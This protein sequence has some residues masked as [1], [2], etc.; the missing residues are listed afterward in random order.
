MDTDSASRI[1][2]VYL[3]SVTEN[4]KGADAHKIV[5]TSRVIMIIDHSYISSK[6]L[7]WLLGLELC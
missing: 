2:K 1:K 6:F 4:T 5:D 3:V 7:L